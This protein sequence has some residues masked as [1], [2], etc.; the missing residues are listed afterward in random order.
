MFA[1]MIDDFLDVLCVWPWYSVLVFWSVMWLR[2]RIKQFVNKVFF[3]T[4]CMALNLM[5]MALIL[6]G[7]ALIL[8]GMALNLMGM[9]LNLMGMILNHMGMIPHLR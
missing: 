8:M 1:D 5:G 4:M 3:G 2:W 7:M 9:T 6:M